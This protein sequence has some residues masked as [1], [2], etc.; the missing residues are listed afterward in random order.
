[1]DPDNRPLALVPQDETAKAV[2]DTI[3]KWAK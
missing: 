1:M 3:E 2:A